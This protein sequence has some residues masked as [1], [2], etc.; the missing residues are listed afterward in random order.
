MTLKR[1]KFFVN[2]FQ[3][4]KIY[5]FKSKFFIIFISLYFIIKIN[6]LT[7]YKYFKIINYINNIRI[8]IV[9][10]SLKNGGAERQTSLIIEYLNKVDKFELYLFTRKPK[11]ENDYP[12][13][14]N[15]K[16][17]TFKGN[18]IYLLNEQKIDILIYQQYFIHEIK[19]LNIYL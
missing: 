19:L 9:S 5:L 18:L 3:D 8:G 7:N 10:N 14:N 17:I 12:I 1:R 4:Y 13:D 6:I 16:R 11:N 15:I 2:L